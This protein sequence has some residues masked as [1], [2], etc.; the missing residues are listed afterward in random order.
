MIPSTSKPMH[1]A[2]GNTKQCLSEKELAQSSNDRL[3]AQT[4]SLSRRLEK[5]LAEA[6][7][8][9]ATSKS[10]DAKLTEEQNTTICKYMSSAIA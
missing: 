10:I 7:D 6:Q 5:V 4:A 9:E 8:L 1:P 2:P 3:L